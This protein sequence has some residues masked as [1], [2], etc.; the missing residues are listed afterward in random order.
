MYSNFHYYYTNISSQLTSLSKTIVKQY[1]SLNFNMTIAL[2][3]P[4]HSVRGFKYCTICR[5]T[6]IQMT[7]TLNLTYSNFYCSSTGQDY[8]FRYESL[9][10]NQFFYRT[11]HFYWQKNE[12]TQKFRTHPSKVKNCML[13]HCINN[14]T[15]GRSSAMPCKPLP[16]PNRWRWTLGSRSWSFSQP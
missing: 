6:H 10:Y 7:L 9:N 2:G 13:C 5:H 11:I 15:H 4:I 16:N 8:S 3:P 1:V 12:E 14:P